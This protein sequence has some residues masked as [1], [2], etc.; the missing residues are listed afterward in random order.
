MH[1][2][3]DTQR[4]LYERHAQAAFDALLAR[5][6]EQRE[7]L[8]ELG[9]RRAF[10][11]VGVYEYGD[12]TYHKSERQLGEETDAELADAIFYQHIRVARAAGDLTPE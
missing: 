8:I 7:E 2:P 12:A 4:R 10:R 9:A 6:G 11:D 1:V 3:I 5:L